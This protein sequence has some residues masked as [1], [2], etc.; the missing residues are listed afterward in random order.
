MAENQRPYETRARVIIREA[1]NA[2]ATRLDDELM[3]TCVGHSGPFSVDQIAEGIARVYR[4]P[5]PS[6]VSQLSQAI[7][8][9]EPL[10]VEL[11]T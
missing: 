9:I 11:P 1:L 8:Q 7:R 10:F 3:Q 6:S 4:N 5:T 2:L